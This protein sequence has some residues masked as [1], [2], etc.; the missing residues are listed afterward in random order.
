MAKYRNQLKLSWYPFNVRHYIAEKVTHLSYSSTPWYY[1]TSDVPMIEWEISSDVDTLLGVEVMKATTNYAGR[2]YEGWFAPSI[3]ISFGPHVFKGLPGLILK[4]YDVDKKFVYEAIQVSSA[5]PKH[6][7]KSRKDFK[8]DM[9]R[10]DYIAKQHDDLKGVG[11]TE[12]GII[13]ET[14]SEKLQMQIDKA[15]RNARRW[16]LMIELN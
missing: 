16:Y 8:P 15:K 5:S 12:T 4:V 6:F 3:P 9:S 11:N 2:K 14:K 13:N 7:F 1:T 10:K